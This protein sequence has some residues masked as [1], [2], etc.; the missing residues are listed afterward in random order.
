MRAVETGGLETITRGIYILR[1]LALSAPDTAT[2]TSAYQA[3][4][5]IAERRFTGAS[6][7]ALT[8]LASIH[9][10][11]Y[12][13]AQTKLTQLGA[14]F[15]ATTV[16]VALAIPQDFPSVTFGTLWRSAPEDLELINWITQFGAEETDR[17]LMLIFEGERFTDAWLEKLAS[18]ENIA[19][20]RLKSVRITD[21]GVAPLATLRDLEIL[22][23]LY[24]PIT[25]GAVEW[26]AK[27]DHVG[28]MRLVGNQIS[29]AGSERLRAL[30]PQLDLDFRRGGFLGVACRDNP[31]R[32]TQVQPN[33]AA[34]AAGFQIDDIIL[35]YDGEAVQSM[36]DLTRFISQHDVGKKVTVEIMRDNQ[37]LTRE[38]ELGKWD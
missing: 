31:C 4:Q 21:Q 16:Q 5:Q 20:I 25:D 24:T 17:K 11:R 30:D 29:M 15:S 6:R 14:V 34:E 26:L 2:E 32:I 12:Q 38:V 18:L 3:L 22:E 1:Q 28:R 8:A 23:L 19:V 35:R 27:F 33:T 10:V 13:Q 37:R 36:D 7:R 9:E